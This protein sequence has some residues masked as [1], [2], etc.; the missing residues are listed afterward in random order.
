ML[1]K[2][3]GIQADW[4]KIFAFCAK[5]NKFLEINSY[6]ARLDLPVDLIKLALKHKAKLV[7][8]TDSHHLD[9]IENMKYGVWHTRAAG[10]EKK[11][12]LNTHNYSSLRH[13]LNL[14]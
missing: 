9:Q 12:L 8:N 4:D 2:R 10:V 6:P 3:P 1:N 7:I 5:E 14:T 11:H 13:M